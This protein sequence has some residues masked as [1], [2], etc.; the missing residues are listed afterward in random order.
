MRM[1][2]PLYRR[3]THS[4]IFALAKFGATILFC[5]SP[6]LEVPENIMHKLVTEYGG[7]LEK[8]SKNHKQIRPELSQ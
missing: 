2:C 6:G 3:T 5:P 4:L 1:S 7:E 8:F